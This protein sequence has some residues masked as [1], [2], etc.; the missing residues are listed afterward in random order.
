M[1]KHKEKLDEGKIKLVTFVTF[2]MGFAQAM[3]IY[4]MSTYFKLSIGTENV[5][6]FYAVSYIIFLIILLN[7]H[8]FVRTLGKSNVFYFSLLAKLFV[9]FGLILVEP[10]KIGILLMILYIILG[11]IEWVALDFIIEEVSTDRMSGRIRGMHLTILNAG[12]LFGPFVSTYFLD[13]I[14]FHGV[15]IFALIFNIF[16]FIFALLGFRKVNKRFE[17]KLRVLDI[18]KKVLARKNIMRIYYISFVLEF[19]YALMVIYTPIYL[20][21]LGFSWGEIGKIFTVMLI[22]FVIFQYPAG[23][24]ADKKMGE[25]ELLIFSILIMGIS[26]M[27]IYFMGTGNVVRWALILF[28]TRIGASLI[29]ILRDSY[30]YKRIDCRDVDVIDFFRTSLPMAYIFATIFSSFVFLFLPIEFVFI[31]TGLIVLSAL[32]PAFRLTDNR[33]EKEMGKC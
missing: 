18:L 22:P 30:F 28:I 15:F 21:D 12:F 29:E 16:V 17:Q 26:T 7:L 8:K 4:V 3:L 6:I 9:I 24:L 31:L 25:K 20:R 19:F 5:G 10:S 11:H 14:N 27:L 23:L 2:L 32:Y 33:S 13:K 1:K